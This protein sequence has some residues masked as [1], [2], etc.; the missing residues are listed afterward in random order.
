M[1]NCA[2][3]VQIVVGQIEDNEHT[4]RVESL[5]NHSK[6]IVAYPVVSNV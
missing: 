1:I 3:A 4:F 2:N 6:S 5:G